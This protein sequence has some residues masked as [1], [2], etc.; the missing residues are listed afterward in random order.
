MN[1]GRGLGWRQE[2]GQRTRECPLLVRPLDTIVRGVYS[3]GMSNLN[4]PTGS[5]THLAHERRR[6]LLTRS[7]RLQKAEIKVR[8][9]RDDLDRRLYM[10]HE[11]GSSITELSLAAGISRETV[12]RSLERVRAD[13]AA[14]NPPKGR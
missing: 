7:R 4:P 13:L 8:E 10:W 9:A 6:D 1:I 5:L 3:E 14:G 2:A 11:D 12:Y